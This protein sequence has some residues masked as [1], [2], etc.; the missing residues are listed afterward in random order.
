MQRRAIWKLVRISIIFIP[1]ILSAIFLFSPF[2]EFPLESEEV[3]INI[4]GN[5]SRETTTQVS[6]DH[7]SEPSFRNLIRGILQVPFD[8]Q[9]YRICFVNEDS[10]IVYAEYQDP[11]YSVNVSVNFNE[12]ETRL[13][14][15]I[16]EEKC[17]IHNLDEEFIFNWE[18]TYSANISKVYEQ[19]PQRID[20][21]NGYYT[22]DY[23]SF[24]LDQE[25]ESYAK[26]ETKSIIV[27]NILIFLSW[28]GIIWL[29]TRMIRFVKYGLDK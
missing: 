20:L 6:T 15:P 22:Y 23:G 4:D 7:F 3:I 8:L 21:G 10:K 27:K 1:L 18:F 14:I 17:I 26:P 5:I 2:E 28:C 19:V 9:W 24:T 29:I 11:D 25:V 12:G 16:G 13:E